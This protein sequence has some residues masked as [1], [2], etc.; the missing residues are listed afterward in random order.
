MA[1]NLIVGCGYLG[2][3]VAALWRGQER[4]VFATTRRATRFD[5]LRSLGF[6]PLLG[7]VLE[8]GSLRSLPTVETLLYC[9]GLDRAAGHPMRRVYVEGLANVL[10]ALAE[11]GRM[12]ARFLYVSSTSVY[13]QTDGEEVDET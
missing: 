10:D 8:R 13:G 5:E 1:D 11:T 3:R 7:D 12:P 6:D 4:R 9:V 2:R